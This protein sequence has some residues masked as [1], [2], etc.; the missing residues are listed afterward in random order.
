MRR[1]GWLLALLLGLSGLGSVSAQEPLEGRATKSDLDT[2]SEF[3]SSGNV[4]P[5]MWFYLEDYRRYKNPK[6]AVRR[7]A[8]AASQQRQNRLAA[9]KWYGV[10]NSRPSVNA[11]PFYS[12]YSPSWFGGGWNP[13]GWI[14]GGSPQAT[15]YTAQRAR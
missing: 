4:T 7:K 9:Q 14:S 1:Q 2:V 13:Y 15:Y 6:E 8:A 12:S 11:I 3:P 10:S 5:E